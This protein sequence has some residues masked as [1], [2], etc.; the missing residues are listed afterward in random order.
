[1][2]LSSRYN[3][4][5]TGTK[6]GQNVEIPILYDFD[7]NDAPRVNA[8]KNGGTEPDYPQIG[9]VDHRNSYNTYRFVMSKDVNSDGKRDLQVWC[10]PEGGTWKQTQYVCPISGVDAITGIKFGSASEMNADTESVTYKKTMEIK[11]ISIKQSTPFNGMK[12]YDFTEFTVGE[13]ISDL[14]IKVTPYGANSATCAIEKD[15]IANV[16]KFSADTLNNGWQNTF[17]KFDFT[18]D[19]LALQNGDVTIDF[20]AKLSS[21]F[22]FKILGEKDGANVEITPIFCYDYNDPPRANIT[23]SEGQTE[24][25]LIGVSNYNSNYNTY[26]FVIGKDINNDKCPLNIWHKSENGTWIHVA[27]V[28]PVSAVDKIIGI[29]FSSSVSFDN[30]TQKKTIELKDIAVRQGNVISN[31]GDLSAVADGKASLNASVFNITDDDTLKGD[32]IVALKD[33][34]GNLFGVKANPVSVKSGKTETYPFEF[35]GLDANKTYKTWVYLWNDV[36]SMEPITN[37]VVK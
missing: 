34:D 10:K 5:L 18:F 3:I 14:P 32:L 2:K 4:S 37:A 6:D 19:E 17:H 24:G 36:T 25:A 29:R 31:V 12:K 23:N 7:W 35:T 20:T 27:N 33:A 30:D 15:G 26:R 1:M 21:R 8:Y 16:L 28:D 22:D 11:S 13:D 9:S